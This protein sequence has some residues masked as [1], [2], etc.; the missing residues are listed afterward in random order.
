[1]KNNKPAFWTILIILIICTILAGCSN[2]I[3]PTST[4]NQNSEQNVTETP[5]APEASDSFKIKLSESVKAECAEEGA[6]FDKVISF[7]EDIVN[8]GIARHSSLGEA[9]GY[10]VIGAEITSLEAMPSA[11]VGNTGGRTLYLLEYRLTA[12]EPQ[13]VPTDNGTVLDGERITEHTRRGQPY[14]LVEWEYTESDGTVWTPLTASYT[15]EVERFNSPEMSEH[16]DGYYTAASMLLYSNY[17]A[18]TAESIIPTLDSSAAS[19]D[20][21]LDSKYKDSLSNILIIDHIVGAEACNDYVD[22]VFLKQT[23]EEMAALPTVYQAIKYFGIS[24]EDFQRENLKNHSG[25]VFSDETVDALYCGDEAEMKRR[26]INGN[27][28]CYDGE[29]YTFEELEDKPAV[30]IPKK[31]LR[32][33]L[34]FIDDYYLMHGDRIGKSD[35]EE[36]RVNKVREEHGLLYPCHD[37]MPTPFPFKYGT[38]NVANSKFYMPVGEWPIGSFSTFGIAGEKVDKWIDDL[39]STYK[40]PSDLHEFPNL[41]SFV[42]YFDISNEDLRANLEIYLEPISITPALLT[43]KELDLILSRDEGALLKAFA[44]EYS[45]VVGKKVYSPEWLYQNSVESWSKAGITPADIKE[46]IPLYKNIDFTVRA[47][48]AFS[49][50]ISEFIGERITLE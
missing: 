30:H 15:D 5:E 21:A 31:I 4:P 34:A 3:A 2:D 45:I 7:A 33:F 40:A 16:Y 38:G 28:L 44:S 10:K 18:D 11:A 49:K 27:A 17:L 1:M 25:T 24:R 35:V 13:N 41:Y 43:E 23:P 37:I 29:I 19:G 26:L 47:N 42:E 12:D 20:H 32:K 14:I 39:K 6:G 50:K 36:K 48:D 46:R 9:K 22:N 8:E